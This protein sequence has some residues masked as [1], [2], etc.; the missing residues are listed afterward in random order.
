MNID[1]LKLMRAVHLTAE[2][3]GLGDTFWVSGGERR[4]FVHYREESCDCADFQLHGGL[5]KHLLCA[6]LY[7]GEGTILRRLRYIVPNPDKRAY[8]RQVAA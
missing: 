2:P 8:R 4:H 3:T 1:L 5:C 7:M 6:G